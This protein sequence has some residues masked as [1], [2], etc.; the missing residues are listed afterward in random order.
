MGAKYLISFLFVSSISMQDARKQSSAVRRIGSREVADHK[1]GGDKESLNQLVRRDAGPSSLPSNNLNKLP[2]RQPTMQTI[3][4]CLLAADLDCTTSKG[5]PCKNLSMPSTNYSDDSGI[6]SLTFQ[7]LNSSCSESSN[8]QMLKSF[9]ADF[10]ELTEPSRID[11]ITDDGHSLLVSPATN[12]SFGSFF[13]V[14]Y[15]DGG[16][17]KNQT[18]CLVVSSDNVKMQQNV[19]DTTGNS[20]IKSGDKF[21]SLEVDAYHDASCFETLTYTIEIINYVPVTAELTRLDFTTPG[22]KPTSLLSSLK[23]IE[24][25]AGETIF[26]ERERKVNFCVGDSI[27][28]EF[29]V[30]A[31]SIFGNSC[32][33]I[34]SSAP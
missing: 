27:I 4:Q 31:K 22:D 9:C 28:A 18:D 5:V 14:S 12:L 26:L 16:K 11:C 32:N 10:Q 19:I 15:P 24:V 20:P 23:T 25:G 30:E 13:T 17:L 7:Y 6:V 3:G 33:I 8:K 34:T 1:Y 29:V 2:T 21:G